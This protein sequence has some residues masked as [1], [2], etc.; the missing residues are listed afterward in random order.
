MPDFTAE[1]R[2]LVTLKD[3][4]LQERVYVARQVLNRAHREGY[5]EGYEQAMRDRG[6]ADVIARL[7]THAAQ[8]EEND[9]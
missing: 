3:D 5:E 1:I 9:V 6:L 4:D 8:R 7:E 2:Q